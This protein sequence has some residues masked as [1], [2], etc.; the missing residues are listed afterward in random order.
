MKKKKAK[1]ASSARTAR[2][3][4]RRAP[5]RPK[6]P[7]K[8]SVVAKEAVV[9]KESAAG[10]QESVVPEP[11]V[12]EAVIQESATQES[13]VTADR[14]YALAE[15]CTIAGAESL[16]A[17]LASL[18]ESPAAVRIDASSVRRI[19]T[20]GLQVLTAFVRERSSRGGAVEWLGVTPALS[21][22]ARIL[23]LSTMLNLPAEASQAA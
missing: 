21:E 17:D 22:G 3:T 9:A 11:L 13:A 16:K 8:A 19:D 18:L 15:E 14:P 2:V 4:R 23:G 7:A 10:A 5:A 1:R 12:P 20:A 6:R